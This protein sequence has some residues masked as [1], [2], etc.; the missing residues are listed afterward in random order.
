MILGLIPRNMEQTQRRVREQC[1]LA[2]ARVVFVL[3][4]LPP[5]TFKAAPQQHCFVIMIWVPLSINGPQRTP[6]MLAVV[7]S[8]S[9][10]VSLCLSFFLSLFLSFFISFSLSLSLYIYIH[11]HIQISHTHICYV[12]TYIRHHTHAPQPKVFAQLP[13]PTKGPKF[14]APPGPWPARPREIQREDLQLRELMGSH[15]ANA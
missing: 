15:K 13:L 1:H 9:L 11:I 7:L 10:S 3:V 14:R 8:L 2:C 5:Q 12:E 6:H 4:Q